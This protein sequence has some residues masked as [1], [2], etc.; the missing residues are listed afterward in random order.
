MFKFSLEQ[1]VFN[2]I[3][4]RKK[5]IQQDILFYIVST[6]A[7]DKSRQEERDEGFSYVVIFLRCFF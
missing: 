3:K 2:K 1:S 7:A 5:T 4:R 6:V